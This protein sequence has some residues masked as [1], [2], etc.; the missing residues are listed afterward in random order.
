MASNSP[1]LNEK[2]DWIKYTHSYTHTENTRAHLFYSFIIIFNKTEVKG[3]S[4][5][6]AR[7]VH[8]GSLTSL[9]ACSGYQDEKKVLLSCSDRT[10]PQGCISHCYQWLSLTVI[11]HTSCGWSIKISNYKLIE[12]E[13]RS[14]VDPVHSNNGSFSNLHIWIH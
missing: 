6:Q 1:I 13:A 14:R 2:N 3:S 12:L 7:L 8:K 10:S 5:L 4:H 9:T 11:S